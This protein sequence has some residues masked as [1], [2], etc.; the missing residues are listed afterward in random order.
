MKPAP[1][2]PPHS[3]I[4]DES[5]IGRSRNVSECRSGNWW[6]DLHP[7]TETRAKAWTRVT[8]GLGMASALGVQPHAESGCGQ[9]WWRVAESAERA[10]DGAAAGQLDG[11]RLGQPQELAGHRR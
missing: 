3:D 6:P 8:V 1:E 4:L 9:P 2:L 5:D 7:K 10:Q 11:G